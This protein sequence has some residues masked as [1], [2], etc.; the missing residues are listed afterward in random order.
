MVTWTWIVVWEVERSSQV[1][2]Y[3]G[4]ILKVESTEFTV[5]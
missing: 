2:M 5:G 1:C 4:H 3:S